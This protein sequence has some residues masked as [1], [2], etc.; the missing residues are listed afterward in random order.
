MSKP[1]INTDKVI[2]TT[3]KALYDLR[4]IDYKAMSNEEK[5]AFRKELDEVEKLALSILKKIK[6]G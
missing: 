5:V 3:K 1:K 2:T 6:K 4:D